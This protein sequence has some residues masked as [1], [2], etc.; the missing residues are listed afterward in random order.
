MHAAVPMGFGPAAGFA[1]G[2]TDAATAA[3][4]LPE[5]KRLVPDRLCP[6]ALPV[7]GS[8]IDDVWTLEEVP[9]GGA[10]LI[11][12]QWM[13]SVDEAWSHHGVESHPSKQV[14]AAPGGEIQGYH[15]SSRA[16]RVRGCPQQTS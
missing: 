6:D 16:H 15:V 9:P 3:A 4:R 10:E 1:Q 14:N 2:M 13:T 7:W 12:P 11:G 8:I 5:A